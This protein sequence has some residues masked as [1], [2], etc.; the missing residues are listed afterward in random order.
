MSHNI[1]SETELDI[2]NCS[3]T[4]NNCIIKYNPTAFSK[5]ERNASGDADMNGR[6]YVL[7]IKAPRLIY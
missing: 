3:M 1:Y 4:W 6:K 2:M 5:Y 7:T